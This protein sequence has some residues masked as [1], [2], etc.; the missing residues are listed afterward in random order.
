MENL[1]ITKENVLKAA[2][3]NPSSRK[4]LE[5]MFP[6][7][8]KPAFKLK[9]GNVVLLKSKH[10]T[11][12]YLAASPAIRASSETKVDMLSLKDSSYS[13]SIRTSMGALTEEDVRIWAPQTIE[14]RVFPSAI[15]PEFAQFL[16]EQSLTSEQA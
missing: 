9:A 2:A 7:A 13:G 4:T 5:A 16:V 1:K 11:E 15:S 10:E 3:E 8:F 6:E 14:V 12:Y